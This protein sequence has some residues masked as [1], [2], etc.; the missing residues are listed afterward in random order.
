MLSS[1]TVLISPEVLDMA[2]NAAVCG[3]GGDDRNQTQKL[4]FNQPLVSVTTES[5]L[6]M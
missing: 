4:K 6:G 3:G 2:G 5:S 1:F